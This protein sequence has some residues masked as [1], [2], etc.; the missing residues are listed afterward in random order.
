MQPESTPK[1]LVEKL[2]DPQPGD[3]IDTYIN[4]TLIITKREESIVTFRYDKF[5]T[6][7]ILWVDVFERKFKSDAEAAAKFGMPANENL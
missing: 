4:G 2:S 1:S 7:E 6:E 5:G 3:Q